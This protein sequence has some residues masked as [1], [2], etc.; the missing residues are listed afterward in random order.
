[1]TA[2]NKKSVTDRQ[3]NWCA[4]STKVETGRWIF[5]CFIISNSNKSSYP[6]G[7]FHLRSQ[8][9][10]AG[11]IAI[12]NTLK[13]KSR[14]SRPDIDQDLLLRSIRHSSTNNPRWFHSQTRK[15]RFNVKPRIFFLPHV[16]RVLSEADWLRTS[17]MSLIFLNRNFS[18]FSNSFFLSLFSSCALLLPVFSPWAVVTCIIHLSSRRVSRQV[19]LT[20]NVNYC[21]MCASFSLLCYRFLVI[22]NFFKKVTSLKLFFSL[23]IWPLGGS[24][25]RQS[26][27]SRHF[28]IRWFCS[29]ESHTRTP[30]SSKISLLFIIKVPL[31][32][33]MLNPF[34]HHGQIRFL[35]Y[36]SIKLYLI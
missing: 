6:T 23:K 7:G 36:W 8:M 13:R 19:S 17:S 27:R 25:I 24:I 28:Q 9:R 10:P 31:F 29:T 1:M 15:F 2:T 32:N 22:S 26:I 21:R 18:F 35:F 4:A 5:R 3:G 33:S 30:I 20:N 34:S 11:R 14:F 16:R 12:F